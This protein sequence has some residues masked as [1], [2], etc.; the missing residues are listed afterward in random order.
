M[1]DPPAVGRG[2]DQEMRLL[3]KIESANEG[4]S[5]RMRTKRMATFQH[6]VHLASGSLVINGAG[7]KSRRT[8]KRSGK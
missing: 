4:A 5:E 1:V 3:R 2:H 6:L 7:G 8:M